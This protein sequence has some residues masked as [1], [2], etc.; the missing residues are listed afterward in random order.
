MPEYPYQCQSCNQEFD[1]IKSVA[2]IDH[3]EPCKEC[4]SDDTQ[5][6]IAKVNLEKSSMAQPYYEPA[7]GCIIKGKGHKAQVLKEKGLEEV[8]STSPD[9]MYKNLELEREKRMAKEWDE[10]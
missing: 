1:I 10:L 9:T 3:V 6:L 7:L 2:D 5:R 4:G 8:G